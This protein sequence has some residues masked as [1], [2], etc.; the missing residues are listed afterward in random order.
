MSKYFVRNIVV[1][2]VLFVSLA[3]AIPGSQ[4]AVAVPPTSLPLD[5]I[6]ANT[7]SAAQTQTQQAN[8]VEQAPAT[9]LATATVAPVSTPTPKVSLNGTSL[10]IR[11]DQSTVFIDHKAGIELSIPSGWLAVR[12]NEPEYYAAFTSNA[13]MANSAIMDRL[14]EIQ[15]LDPNIFRYEAIDIRD[16]HSSDGN[17][18]I[19][20][21]VFQEGALRSLEEIEKVEKDSFPPF[22]NAKLIGT[23]YSQ[24]TNGLRILIIEK[25]WDGLGEITIYHRG[26]FFSLPSG[27]FVIDSYID[28]SMK[29][30][31]LPEIEQ[32]IN[33]VTLLNP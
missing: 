30:T 7:A 17:L 32:V 19:I 12:I 2:T 14:T 25:S 3:C 29:D 6:I 20:N 5:V 18:N 26:I 15:G 33:S 16:G 11:E 10:I 24:T 13:V 9:E 4:P 27:V 23:N 21:S 1:G 22:D 31:I 8:P 28:I